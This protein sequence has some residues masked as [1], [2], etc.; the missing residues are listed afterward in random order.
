MGANQ[1]VKLIINADDLGMSSGVNDAIFDLM[2]RRRITSATLIANGAAV[3]AAAKRVGAFPHCSFGIHLNVTE[4][5]PLTRNPALA[6]L[7]DDLGRF[8]G[9]AIG[10]V[11]LTAELRHAVFDELSAQIQRIADLGVNISHLDSHHHIHTI[12]G[13]F[14]VIKRLQK[15]FGIRRVRLTL[16]IYPPHV[17]VSRKLLLAK[18]F[19]SV[20]MRRWHSTRTTRGFA[21]FQGFC[22]SSPQTLRRFPSIEM[23]T[24]PGAEFYEAETCVLNEPWQERLAFATQLISYN[25]L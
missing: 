20:A 18:S 5:E 17:P 7:L 15:R 19:W 16:N 10:S 21:S 2:D 13:L 6:P 1:P 23:M 12:A 3:E 4:F 8:Q 9:K 24:H 11:K 14:G 25:E 22:Q